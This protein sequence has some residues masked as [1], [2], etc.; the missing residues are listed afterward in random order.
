MKKSTAEKLMN[1]LMKCYEALE[2]SELVAREIE[3]K[4]LQVSIT[5]G[6]LLTASELEEGVMSKVVKA[7]PEL[8]PFAKGRPRTF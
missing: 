8:N 5:K 1:S 4:E 7:Y 3:E 6:I 2:A